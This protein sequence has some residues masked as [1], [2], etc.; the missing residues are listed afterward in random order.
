MSALDPTYN[1]MSYH[2]GSI[3]PHDNAIIAAGLS[4]YGFHKEMTHLATEVLDAATTFPDGRLPELYCG[5]ARGEDEEREIAPAAYPVSCSPQAWA[6][7]TP[8]LQVTRNVEVVREALQLDIYI[9]LSRFEWQ[10]LDRYRIILSLARDLDLGEAAH[11][12]RRL[13]DVIGN[14]TD[15]HAARSVLQLVMRPLMQ[16]GINM[17]RQFVSSLFYAMPYTRQ[18]QRQAL[19]R[20]LPCF[21]RLIDYVGE[22]QRRMQ[23]LGTL[24]ECALRL[25]ST[26]D[27][28]G[29]V[30]LDCVLDYLAGRSQELENNY[31]DLPWFVPAV[32]IA[33]ALSE[34]N[35]T[36]FQAVFRTVIEH[37]LDYDWDRLEEGLKVINRLSGFRA[38]LAAM[39]PKQPHRCVKLLEQMSLLPRLGEDAYST[40]APEGEVPS[41]EVE[42]QDLP[43]SWQALVSAAPELMSDAAS[44]IRAHEITGGNED[45]PTGLRHILEQPT[46]W[47]R[48]LSYLETLRQTHP[49][50]SDLATREHNLRMRLADNDTL[51]DETRRE[52]TECLQYL[53]GEAQFAAIER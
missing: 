26:E 14:F 31:G 22:D 44:Y 48:E 1:P 5:F 11:L 19:A 16:M 25:Q 37:Q 30:W 52:L 33:I 49:S 4:R 7:G 27:G 32:A 50:R 53:L 15:L 38:I 10:E 36:Q 40:F 12:T 34:G 24:M 13:C 28:Q 42:V 43:V 39:F 45:L 29:T 35:S 46:K 51:L 21:P 8:M 17:R 3:W 9:T 41:S 20:L 18:G 2:N 6:A 47:A 23:V